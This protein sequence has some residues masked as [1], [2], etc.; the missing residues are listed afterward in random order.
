M[1]LRTTHRKNRDGSVATYHQ[2]AHNEWDPATG[3][4]QAKILHSFG[5]QD[6]A[7]YADLKRLCHSVGKV[8][9]LDVREP[10][11][12]AA[13]EAAAPGTTD[14]PA[15]I[16]PVLTRELG[17]VHVIEALWERLGIGPVL[18]RLATAG[19]ARPA[20]ERALLAMTANRL[21]DP[22]SKLGVWERWLPKV[23]LP[24]CQ[25]FA[26]DT[27]FDAMDFLH[28]HGAHVEEAVFRQ[29]ADLLNLEVD[30][31]V[32]D[33]TTASFS[34]DEEDEDEEVGA[35]DGA[36]AAG[37]YGVAKGKRTGIRKVS[38]NKEG[39][40][41]PQVVV[42]LAVTREG[43]PVRS[44]VFPGNTS[45]VTTVERVK[46]D[47]KGWQLHRCLFVADA[48][49]NSEQNRHELAKACGKYLLAVRAAAVKEVKEE[50]FTRPGRY[51][52]VADNLR[53]KE[54]V[55]GD[56]VLARRYLV[57]HNPREERRQRRHREEVLAELTVELSRHPDRKATAK[58]AT[59]LQTSQR[60]SPYLSVDAAGDLEVDLEKAKAAAKYDGKWVLITNDDTLRP[61]D[62][63]AAYK[64]GMVIERCFRSLK[65]VQLRMTPMHHW[66]PHRIATHVKI[67][68]L[69]LLIER[70]AEVTTERP[71]KRLCERLWT[72][73]ATEFR[74]E[75]PGM[76]FWRANE[77]APEAAE[78][79]KALG[80]E[81]PRAFLG[82][83]ELRSTT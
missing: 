32:Y 1:Y 42:A 6:P 83:E 40:W 55:V 54:V 31:V 19:H 41:H 36:A 37:G 69:A 9:G 33:T 10:A 23:H 50:V 74:S 43:L 78:V 7:D 25:G 62:A 49:M 60:Y 24:S 8:C 34:I 59:E 11:A 53:V 27:F 68:V 52:A 79:L 56:G 75:R 14:L 4:S 44:W 67:C 70:V 82:V 57:C 63:A 77:L 72:I 46:A 76:R 38:K 80:V 13:V 66:L 47:L 65:R 18:R 71:W 61:A 3:S 22:E 48:G 2:L 58:W 30:L 73:Q 12:S 16:V 51:H 81:R 45:D 26:L 15:G 17:R 21:C 29:M 5:R 64:A 35:D 28:E 20:Y 39:T